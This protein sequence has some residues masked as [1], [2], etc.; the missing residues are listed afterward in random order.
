MV[1]H[2]P[3]ASGH[4]TAGVLG[5]FCSPGQES[6]CPWAPACLWGGGEESGGAIT[7]AQ[8]GLPGRRGTLGASRGIPGETLGT[9][10]APWEAV[11][12]RRP[13]PVC[14]VTLV[15]PVNPSPTAGPPHSRVLERNESTKHNI[16]CLQP[17]TTWV[18]K[19]LFLQV[20][21][22]AFLTSIGP[23]AFP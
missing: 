9:K 17:T 8:R 22:F 14:S 6:C 11:S 19:F 4:V 15:R 12:E 20:L 1:T 3:G 18:S 13:V 23:F 7:T 16:C 2:W 5:G 10:P 21:G